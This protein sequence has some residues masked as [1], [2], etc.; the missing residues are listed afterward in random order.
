VPRLPFERVSSLVGISSGAV[1]AWLDRLMPGPAYDDYTLKIC[2]GEPPRAESEAA[3]SSSIGLDD[4]FCF[5]LA[6]SKEGVISA[7]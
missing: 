4:S 1:L 3:Q 6:S 2:Y 7:G 5:L